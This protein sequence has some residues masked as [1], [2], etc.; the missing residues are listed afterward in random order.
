[1]SSV[2][3]IRISRPSSRHPRVRQP[4]DNL[5]LWRGPVKWPDHPGPADTVPAGRDAGKLRL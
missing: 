1:M 3:F 2:R 4:G 5:S